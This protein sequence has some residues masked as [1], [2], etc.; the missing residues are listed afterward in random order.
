VRVLEIKTGAAGT[1]H[2]AQL[3]AYVEAV[4]EAYPT[5]TVEGRV[6]YVAGAS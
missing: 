1:A 6:I 3:G 5:R 4:R 2:S